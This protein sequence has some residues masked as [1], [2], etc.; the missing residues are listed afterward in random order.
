VSVLA[1]V[2]SLALTVSAGLSGK[3]VDTSGGV[4]PGVS[5]VVLDAQHNP[6]SQKTITNPQGEFVFDA[7][8]L[9]AEIELSLPGFATRRMVIKTSPATVTLQVG[10]INEIDYVDF[11][12]TGASSWR[13]ATTGATTLTRGD[14]DRVPAMTPDES[15]RVISGFSLFR[16][17][18][19]RASNP[20]THGVTMRGLSA[21]GSSRALVVFS[22]IPLNDGFGGWVTWERLPAAAIDKIT[23]QRGPMSDVFGSDA[24]GGAITIAPRS[25]RRMSGAAS[26]EVASLDTRAASISGGGARNS[27]IVFGAASWFDT[28]GFIPI[29]PATRGPADAPADT[30]W[31]NAYGRGSIGQAHRLTV[32]GWGGND[33]RG[34]GTNEQRNA[35][36]GGTGVAAYEMTA[37]NT[38]FAAR[39]SS[40]VNRYEQTFTTVLTVAGV[41]RASERFISQQHINTDVMRGSVELRRSLSKAVAALRA[42]VTRTDSDFEEI[43][44]T[45][46]VT[47]SLVDNNQSVSGQLAV[48]PVT[49]LTLS[50]GGR[51]EWRK[52]GN[53]SSPVSPDPAAVGRIAA[54]WK[55]SNIVTVRAAAGSSH[56]W[57]TLN[58]LVRN[59]S[60]GTVTTV[61]NTDLKPERARSIEAGL[62]ATNGRFQA[63]IT[64]FRSIVRDAIANVTT[65]VV[66]SAI[67]RQRQ[68]AGEAHS[69]G[70]ELDASANTKWLRLRG[71]ATILDARFRKSKEPALE[72]N[73]L[74]QVPRVSFAGTADLLL[75]GRVVASLVVHK[76]STQ[77]DD[78]RNTAAFRMTDATQVDAQVGGAFRFASWYVAAENLGDARI[79]T[80]R[81]GSTTAPLIT[82]A[83]GRAVR[84]GLTIRLQKR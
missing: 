21:S 63:S 35:S 42:S 26:L 29:E 64:G 59:F 57:P 62:D 52:A 81:S 19:S 61:A 44:T 15:L 74:P 47:K 56:R 20:T 14:L 80:G 12:G 51:M 55:L 2:V 37:G 65:S 68:N 28:F 66:G 24:L 54:A 16:R 69:A 39:G 13:D 71:S 78:D 75:P 27:A 9:P 79:E 43:Q 45:T 36:H 34:N 8:A 10:E 5:V 6:T 17:S 83:Q 73:W 18:S 25:E 1:L 30:S 67:T 23:V 48:T 60:A 53:E 38:L 41:S 82:L 84:A 77:F 50:A 22:G 7:V 32:S 46:T 31:L 72:G 11:T 33:D 40:S 76:V 70:V 58:E 4:I 3:V 49:A